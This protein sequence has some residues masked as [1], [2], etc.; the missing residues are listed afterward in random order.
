MNPRATLRQAIFTHSS[1]ERVAKESGIHKSR[2]SAIVRGRISPNDD[3]RKAIARV[4]RQPVY[5]L[6]PGEPKRARYQ[7]R[8]S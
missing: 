7:R 8:A 5:V 2:L 4:L 1:Q 3:E 6:F